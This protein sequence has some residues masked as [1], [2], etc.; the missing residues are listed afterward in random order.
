MTLRPYKFQLV[1]IAQQLDDDGTVTGEATI[2][3]GESGQ[4]FVLFGVD[5]LAKW[6]QDFPGLLDQAGNRDSAT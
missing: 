2:G 3:A 1:A 4:P 6:A 5:A